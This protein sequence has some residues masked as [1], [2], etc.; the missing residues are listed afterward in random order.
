MI[1]VKLCSFRV[2]NLKK[3]LI[4]N[5]GNGV[6]VKYVIMLRLLITDYFKN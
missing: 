5:T 4:N 3:K 6:E 2:L 1:N